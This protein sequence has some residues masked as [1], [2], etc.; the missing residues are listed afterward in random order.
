MNLRVL[1]LRQPRAPPP[2]PPAD[3]SR[4]VCCQTAE[5]GS[6]WSLQPSLK[7]QAFEITQI[8]CA[9]PPHSSLALHL[10]NTPLAD[11]RSPIRSSLDSSFSWWIPICAAGSAVQKNSAMRT[12]S[13]VSWRPQRAKPQ[14][15]RPK[16]K[17]TKR[18]H[19]KNAEPSYHQAL[20]TI[21]AT[22]NESKFLSSP[23]TNK[24][25]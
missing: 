8:L 13:R 20:S 7:L 24:T 14:P 5:Y 11:V 3:H 17:T 15:F 9:L 16:H 1:S 6:P 18:T 2:R 12:K 10:G 4:G 21:S 19:S 22:E 23:Q 25:Q